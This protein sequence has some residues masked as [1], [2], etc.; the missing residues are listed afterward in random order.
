MHTS[1]MYFLYCALKPEDVAGKTVVEV[2]SYNVNGSARDL[3]ESWGPAHYLGLDIRPGPGVDIVMDIS[4]WE[5]SLWSPPAPPDLIVC[6]ETLE[7]V[8]DWV[9]AVGRMKRMLAPGGLI[10][11][12]TRSPGFPRHEH[13]GDF[14]R[15][16]LD[17]MRL[18]FA[19][20]SLITLENDPEF[21]GVFLLARKPNDW[22]PSPLPRVEVQPVD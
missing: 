13:P 18:A 17:D 19:D 15:F 2:G 7:H 1:V 3:L 8:Q 6:T 4:L 22:R 20:F 21:P 12:T 11:L 14:W 10:V 9:S 5:E 16:T